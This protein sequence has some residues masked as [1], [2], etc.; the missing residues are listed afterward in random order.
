MLQPSPEQPPRG[1]T[2]GGAA[3]GQRNESRE[4]WG[5]SAAGAWGVGVEARKR[6]SEIWTGKKVGQIFSGRR[7]VHGLRP[8][9]EM[10][11]D[12][13][14]RGGSMWLA[15]YCL[16]LANSQVFP[17]SFFLSPLRQLG[18]WAPALGRFLAFLNL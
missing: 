15:G 5:D 13:A 7:A 17:S 3:S 18:P 4:K 9:R 12:P 2:A 11:T 6:G 8:K 10:R 16:G 14:P 1:K